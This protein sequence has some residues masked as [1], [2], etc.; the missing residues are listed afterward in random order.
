MKIYL[1]AILI[2]SSLHAASL[3]VACGGPGGADSS[4]NVWQSDIS[5]VG[6]VTWSANPGPTPP[7]YYLRYGL[8][9]SYKFPLPSGKYLLTLKFFEPNKTGPNQRLFKVVVND[10]PILTSID[11]FTHSGAL[12]PYDISIP[13]ESILGQLKIQFIGLIGN[14][15]ISGIRVDDLNFRLE[16]L[17]LCQMPVSC[18]GVYQAKFV[19]ADGSTLSIIGAAMEANSLNIWT[20][21]K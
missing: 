15:I 20:E 18:A 19:K 9:F 13:V 4:N 5:Y 8:S 12:T 21:V 16:S 7:Y 17:K 3:R 11:I 6:G 10:I 14:A 1:L 2:A